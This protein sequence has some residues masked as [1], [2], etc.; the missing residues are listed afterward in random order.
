[1][2]TLDSWCSPHSNGIHVDLLQRQKEI[3]FF[4][5]PVMRVLLHSQA[6]SWSLLTSI[7]L[8]TK[9]REFCGHIAAAEQNN[10]R[11]RKEERSL[12]FLSFFSFLP[13]SLVYQWIYANRFDKSPG[14]PGKRE[15][16]RLI[17]SMLYNMQMCPLLIRELL[18]LLHSC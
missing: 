13:H 18:I 17:N 3:L 16:L 12:F 15:G 7:W 5:P 14:S 6:R 9:D 11:R 4:F 8:E 10:K 1:M 2:C